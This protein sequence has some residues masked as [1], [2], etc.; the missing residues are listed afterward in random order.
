MGTIIDLQRERTR[1]RPLVAAMERLESAVTR[2]D[3][4]VRSRGDRLGTLIQAELVSIHEAVRNGRPGE[5]AEL[6]EHLADRLE[7]PAALGS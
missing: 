7:H 5:A 3:P 6:A 2:L 1:R 4:L